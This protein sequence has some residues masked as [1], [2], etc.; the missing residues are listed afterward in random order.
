MILVKVIEIIA[1]AVISIINIAA[2]FIVF[3]ISYMYSMIISDARVFQYICMHTY[4]T[5]ELQLE[6]CF[7]KFLS[8]TRKY[9]AFNK[10]T[11]LFT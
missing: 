3:N 9:I 4:S 10:R 11:Q 6:K 5:P 7:H 1:K 8:E 2:Y